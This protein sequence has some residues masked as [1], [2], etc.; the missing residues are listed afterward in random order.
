[1]IP[2]L[3]CS[4]IDESNPYIREWTVFAIRNLTED[5]PENQKIIAELRIQ[6]AVDTPI[7]EKA[8]VKIELTDDGKPKLVPRL[9]HSRVE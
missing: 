7:L 4:N 8:G 9:K 1:M 3:N 6:G 5:N 2:V